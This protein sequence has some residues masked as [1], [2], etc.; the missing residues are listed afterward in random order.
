MAIHLR[1]PT[2]EDLRRIG[3]IEETADA[4]LTE[5]FGAGEWGPAPTGAERSAATGFILVSAETHDGPAVGFV[6]VVEHGGVAAHLEQLSVLPASG[7][8]GHGRALL[9]SAKRETLARGYRE[10]TLRTFAEVP[11]NAPFYASGGFVETEP[12]TEALRKLQVAEE[13]LG[14]T[15]FGRRVQMTAVV[16]RGVRSRL[17]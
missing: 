5:F 13:Q 7:R 1:V 14:L 8:R 15:R 16:A 17:T 4:R 3:G 11:F 12:A 6:H 10:L 9:E 2:A